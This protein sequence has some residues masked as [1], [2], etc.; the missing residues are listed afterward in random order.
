LKG[1]SFLMTGWAQR[2]NL[3]LSGTSTGID[4]KERVREERETNG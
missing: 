1:V 3:I 2:N 4:E